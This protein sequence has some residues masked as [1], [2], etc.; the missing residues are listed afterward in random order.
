MTCRGASKISEYVK[1]NVYGTYTRMYINSRAYSKLTCYYRATHRWQSSRVKAGKQCPLSANTWKH[2]CA[3]GQ[4]NMCVTCVTQQDVVQLCQCN[5]HALI[6]ANRS[7]VAIPLLQCNSHTALG[8]VI[9]RC[10]GCH[11]LRLHCNHPGV[12]T[13]HWLSFASLL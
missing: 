2:R 10:P 12:V 11:T 6:L 5:Y 13:L 1:V 8:R 9:L 3:V 7:S 4:L